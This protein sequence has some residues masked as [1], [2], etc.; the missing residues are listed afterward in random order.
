MAYPA[1]GKKVGITPSQ[2]VNISL[3]KGTLTPNVDP[4]RIPV[5]GSVQFNNE[6]PEGVAIELFTRENDKH[7][8]VSL[9]MAP[10]GSVFVCNDPD[11][12]DSVCYYNLRPYPPSGKKITAS[13]SGGHSIII[14]SGIQR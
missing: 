13:T 8:E 12:A 5:G 10:E 7:V 14:N 3:V 6:T 4:A 1:P 11:S 9:Y 2:V